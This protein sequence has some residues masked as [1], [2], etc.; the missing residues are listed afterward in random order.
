MA[1]LDADEMRRIAGTEDYCYALGLVA[2]EGKAEMSE[3]LKSVGGLSLLFFCQREMNNTVMAIHKTRIDALLRRIEALEA[4]TEKGGSILDRKAWQEGEQY[5]AG[6]W[7]THQGSLWFVNKS[8]QSRPG[9]D[10]SYTLAV[11]TWKG[12][13]MSDAIPINTP[14]YLRGLGGEFSLFNGRIVETASGQL[15]D[16]EYA[17]A[18]DWLEHVFPNRMVLAAREKLLPIIPPKTPD[19][20]RNPQ[21]IPA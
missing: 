20:T 2:R 18:A 3:A 6:E 16:G 13:A 7:V 14:C 8:T 21:K 12:C 10:D 4:R 17:V 1:R 11:Q 19:V 15:E 5:N 9:D